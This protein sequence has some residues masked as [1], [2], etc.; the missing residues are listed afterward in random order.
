VAQ[1]T[2]RPDH[3]SASPACRALRVL[4]VDDNRDIVLTLGMLL[5]DEGYEVKGVY[6]GQDAVVEFAEFEP[7][8]VIADIG[9]PKMSGWNLARALRKLS[10]AE[11]PLMI[12]ISGEFTT[13]SDRAR[14]KASG[15]DHFL[16]KPFDAN[17]LIRLIESSR[18]A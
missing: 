15:F 12:A 1:P 18:S 9:L 13:A 6:D 16:P 2:L 8:A 3:S 17:E 14:L 7:D 10:V 11:R 5:E 4:I